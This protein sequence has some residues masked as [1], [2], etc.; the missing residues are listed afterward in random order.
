MGHHFQR[1]AL[2]IFLVLAG[3]DFDTELAAG[4]VLGRHLDG[5]FDVVAEFFALVIHGLECFGLAIEF[6]LAIDL[7]TDGGMGT[8]E[9]T[10]VALDTEFG[11]PGGNF[12]GQVALFPLGGSRRPGAVGGEG[13]DR[14]KVA[15]AGYHHGRH[16]F[17]ELGCLVWH[18]WR[19]VKLR[20]GL[21]GNGNPLQMSQGLVH[22]SKVLVHHLFAFLAVCLFNSALNLSDGFF[23]GQDAGYG[24][25]TGLHNGIDAPPHAGFFGY[26]MGVDD[27]ELELFVDDGLLDRPGQLAPGVRL[28]VGGVEQEGGTGGGAFQHVDGVEE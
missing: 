4:A 3:A 22:G 12:C 26:L 5:I 16:L 27:I 2:G 15:F 11:N 7:D 13:A 28:A 14:Q 8:D 21:F 17:D 20:G 18:N 25:K 6:V 24:K 1:Q 10:F 19:N 9:G 23:T